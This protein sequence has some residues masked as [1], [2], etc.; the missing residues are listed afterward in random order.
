MDIII[1]ILLTILLLAATIFDLRLYRI[2]N[3]LTYSFIIIGLGY[4]TFLSGYEGLIFSLL[5]TLAGIGILFI[6]YLIGW[7]GAGDAKLL[8]AIGAFI[9][10]KDVFIAFLF[11]GIIGGAYAIIIIVLYRNRE[12]PLLLNFY[13]FISNIFLTRSYS[14][15]MIQTDSRRPR[16]CYGLSIAAGTLIYLVLHINHIAVFTL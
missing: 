3:I 15:K 16:L 2:P 13:R 11:S 6:P 7:M 14:F 9:G 5:G 10:A 1:I 4:N 12:E 8:G